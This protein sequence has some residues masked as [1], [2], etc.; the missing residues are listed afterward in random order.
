MSSETQRAMSEQHDLAKHRLAESMARK[1]EA[2]YLIF[3][4][5]SHDT[6]LR[7]TGVID[8]LMADASGRYRFAVG[9]RPAVIGEGEEKM[10]GT[11]LCVYAISP[12]CRE[13]FE[14]SIGYNFGGTAVVA[15]GTNT[16]ADVL[17]VMA[18]LRDLRTDEHLPHL[19]PRGDY[20]QDVDNGPIFLPRAVE[21]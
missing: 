12:D 2:R 7:Q 17:L 4:Q 3:R 10:L 18:L 8:R 11:L 9:D 5:A 16:E 15:G 19:A 21:R 13:Y 1:H 14:Y 6:Q 20:I